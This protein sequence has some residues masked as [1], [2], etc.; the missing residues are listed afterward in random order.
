[1]FA[2]QFSSLL[3]ILE[4]SATLFDICEGNNIKPKNNSYSGNSHHLKQQNYPVYSFN[5]C[6]LR[7]INSTYT[8]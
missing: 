2:I 6:V 8:Y 5:A 1:M 4:I 3:K 7:L